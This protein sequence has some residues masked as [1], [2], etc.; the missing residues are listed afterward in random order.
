MLCVPV[1]CQHFPG[2]LTNIFQKVIE[3]RLI[4]F[5]RTVSKLLAGVLHYNTLIEQSCI[6]MKHDFKIVLIIIL[7]IILS[8]MYG[9]WSIMRKIIGNSEQ[10]NVRNYE[11]NYLSPTWNEKIGLLCSTHLSSAHV[12]YIAIYYAY[13]NLH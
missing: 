1:L 13:C 8:I 5:N 11:H 9:I 6:V 2:K 4:Y 10:N 12:S 3:N 7:R